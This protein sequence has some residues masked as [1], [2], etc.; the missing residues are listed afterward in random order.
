MWQVRTPHFFNSVQK[1]TF[2]AIYLRLIVQF[3]NDFRR[4]NADKIE[5]FFGRAFNF[6]RKTEFF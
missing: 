3:E 5:M 2:L 4:N 6:P 1:N